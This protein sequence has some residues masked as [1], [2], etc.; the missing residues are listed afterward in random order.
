MVDH[1]AQVS[2]GANA[3]NRP[4]RQLLRH[5]QDH[6]SSSVASPCR[7]CSSKG[8]MAHTGEE[9]KKAVETGYVGPLSAST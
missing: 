8:G 1:N 4:S 6:P 3:S 5:Y 2:M 7:E 9:M